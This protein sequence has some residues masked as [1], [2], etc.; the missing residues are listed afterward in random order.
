[1]STI[2]VS[3]IDMLGDPTECLNNVA[4]FNCPHYTKKFGTSVVLNGNISG[5]SVVSSELQSQIFHWNRPGTN[6]NTSLWQCEFAIHVHHRHGRVGLGED[7]SVVRSCR[8]VCCPP[9]EE[10][11]L[12]PLNQ[13][14][15]MQRLPSPTSRRPASGRRPQPCRAGLHS[16]QF[17][18]SDK[19]QRVE[20]AGGN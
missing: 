8:Q 12:D 16:G 18:G 4:V 15:A 2:Q 19:L 3:I 10:D 1:M 13:P 6:R 7:P 11:V 20:A 5:V 9:S 14:A 17:Q